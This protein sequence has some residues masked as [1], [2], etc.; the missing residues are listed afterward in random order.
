MDR[1]IKQAASTNLPCRK[2]LPGEA[3][4]SSADI[5]TDTL[6]AR[7]CERISYAAWCKMQEFGIKYAFFENESILY[8]HLGIWT[9]GH[10]VSDS[11]LSTWESLRSQFMPELQVDVSVSARCVKQKCKCS[12][13]IFWYFPSCF[14]SRNVMLKIYVSLTTRWTWFGWFRAKNNF[15]FRWPPSIVPR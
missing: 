11:R 5:P 12:W 13:N 8:E 9:H 6:V 14:S 1:P 10:W 4:I 3:S 7:P 2:T 15:T